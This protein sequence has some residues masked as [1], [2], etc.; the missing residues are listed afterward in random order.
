MPFQ[1]PPGVTPLMHIAMARFLASCQA[2]EF[3]FC[4]I[5]PFCPAGCYHAQALKLF[6]LRILIDTVIFYLNGLSYGIYLFLTGILYWRFPTASLTIG[7]VK[8]QVCRQDFCSFFGIL[9]EI[10]YQRARDVRR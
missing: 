1:V 3:C 6:P 5:I 10:F 7:T 4:N 9:L 2:C 8:S